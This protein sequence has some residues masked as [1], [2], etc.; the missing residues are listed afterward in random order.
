MSGQQ[1]MVPSPSLHQAHREALTEHYNHKDGKFNAENNWRMSHCILQGTPVIQ[2]QPALQQV[3][4][5]QL[6]SSSHQTLPRSRSV[7]SY[8]FQLCYGSSVCNAPPNVEA[9]SGFSN[10]FCKWNLPLIIPVRKADRL[11]WHKVKED[12]VRFF[13]SN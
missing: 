4:V 6:F 10:L 12:S 3:K 1:K 7:V 8:E 9:V 5:T 2:H 13:L 11:F